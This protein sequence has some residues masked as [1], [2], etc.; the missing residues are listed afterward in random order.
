MRTA[1]LQLTTT[2]LN[3]VL[4]RASQLA[5]LQQQALTENRSISEDDLDKLGLADDAA[6]A[7]QML[8]LER[9]KEASGSGT[10]G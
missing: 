9:M 4:T 3:I 2:I 7:R 5:S 1:D 6:K 10:T 8:Q